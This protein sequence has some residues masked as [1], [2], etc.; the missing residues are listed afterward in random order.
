V[1]DIY[2]PE[3]GPTQTAPTQLP[4]DEHKARSATF[5]RRTF[6]SVAV[7]AVLGV[8]AFSAYGIYAIR[9]TQTSRLKQAETNDTTLTIIRDCTQPK[10]KC[11]ERGQ[12]A[13]A[14]VL[15]DVTSV[16]VLAAAC[17]VDVNPG[18]SV[19]QRQDAI[20]ACITN[21]LAATAP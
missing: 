7:L 15:A 6:L 20:T 3:M 4:A 8:V 19:A 17:A 1:N 12:E 2:P 11:Y 14:Q 10:G 16:I 13:T 5:W 9:T 18:Q 21:R